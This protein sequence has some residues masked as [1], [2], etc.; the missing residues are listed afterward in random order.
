MSDVFVEICCTGYKTEGLMT[1]EDASELL[2]E[3]QSMT[4]QNQIIFTK[5]NHYTDGSKSQIV[6]V[7][8]KRESL[9]MITIREIP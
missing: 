2:D 1:R 4:G 8:V 6:T 7:G 3:W 5:R 9:E